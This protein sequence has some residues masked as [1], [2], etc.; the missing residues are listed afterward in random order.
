MVRMCFHTKNLL[1]FGKMNY[2]AT[3]QGLGK[4]LF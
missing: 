1:P 2:D 4:I 3:T